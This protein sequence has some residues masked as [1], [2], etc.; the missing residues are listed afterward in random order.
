[1]PVAAAQRVG[2]L[3]VVA[4]GA[5][6]ELPADVV[7]ARAAVLD[8]VAGVAREDVV[9][10]FAEDLV[11]AGPAVGDVVALAA[12]DVV[13]AAVAVQRVVAAAAEERLVLR[14]A[15]GTREG[16]LAAAAPHLDG[17]VAPGTPRRSS[18]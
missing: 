8:V 1:M 6:A 4:A 14:S 13:V 2:A 18:R 17:A 16:V 15:G 5:E 3:V 11:V 10:A 12:A 9:A 7:V